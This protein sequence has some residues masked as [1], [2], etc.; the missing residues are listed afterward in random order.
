LDKINQKAVFIVEKFPY[1]PKVAGW[2]LTLACNMNCIHCGSSAGLPR[3]D[4]LSTEEGLSLIDQLTDLGLQ[5]MT[6]SGGEPLLHPSWETYAK[7]LSSAGVDTYII[8]NGLL[9]EKFA[10][11]IRQTGVR[12]ISVSIDGLEETH[13]FIRNNPKSFEKALRGIK[14]ANDAGL[15]TGAVTHISK[16]NIDE[17]ERMYQLFKEINIKLWQIQITFKMGR[18]K[19]NDDFS[20]APESLSR[21]ASFINEKQRIDDGITVVAGDNV[22]YY[23]NLPIRDK[24]WKGCFAGRHL[25]GIDAD[26]A[27][28]GCLSLPREF[29]EGNIRE[30]PLR[31][32]WEDV[33][34]FRY[35]RYFSEDMLQG[36]C[37]GCPKGDPCRAGCVVTAYSSTGDRFS[38]PYCLFRVEKECRIEGQS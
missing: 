1:H 37:K 4:E 38:N 25:L 9:L 28:K 2:E 11:R 8:T 33:N 24:S 29:V 27:I 5:V 17:M 34:R 18:M 21:V 36:Y 14:A 13:N 7:R 30:E 12:R 10:E 19:E 31:T 6:L 16:A 26:G 32:I 22:G 15:F 20:L 3:P 35:N 23:G